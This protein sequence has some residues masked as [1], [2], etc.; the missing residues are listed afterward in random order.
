[1]L[2]EPDFPDEP[3]VPD[4][5]AP[6]NVVRLETPATPADGG[7]AAA[8]T[9]GEGAESAAKPKRGR[10]PK[11][12]ELGVA[13]YIKLVTGFALIYG[14]KTVWDEANRRILPIDALRLALGN[15]AVKGWLASPNRRTVMPEQLVFEPGQSFEDG[16]INMFGGLELEP[17][18][19]KPEDV[20]P[21]LRLLRHLCSGPGVSGDDADAAMHWVLCWM[22]LPLQRLGTKMQTAIVMHG[23]QGTGKNLFWDVWRDLYG[24][25]GVTVSQTELEDKFNEWLSC[26]LAIVGDEVV[27]R[28]EM[29]HN[30]NRLKL[31]VTQSAKFPIR[32]MHQSTRWESNHANVVFL[33]NE[34]QP[35][36]L[37]ERDRRYMVIYT[38]LE[39]DEALYDSVKAFLAADG[40]RKW[41]HYLLTYA[42]EGFTP[43][44]K[45]LMT[46]AKQA[47]ITAGYKP[48]QRF[49]AEW[50]GG[51]LPLAVQVCS[52]EQLYRVF[53]R[54]A[55]QSGERF[56][57][58]REIFSREF[59]RHLVEMAGRGKDP[60]LSIKII[61]LATAT[62][63]KSV[64]CWL[65]LNA[66]P[67]A[68]FS[69][70]GDWATDCVQA[71]ERQ[72]EAYVRATGGRPLD[73]EDGS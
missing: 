34:S 53:R 27:S 62:G 2:P 57:P 67:G 38:P 36:A 18:A 8:K 15:D 60:G 69:S 63:R 23:A 16:R 1:M 39:A 11:A 19:C 64:R 71:F 35:L 52:A 40:A 65:P 43:H 72:I 54:W 3:D 48:S 44:T 56:L 42:V 49:A 24:L 12:G 13:N 22:A 47:L 21:M 58:S 31:V 41:L 46:E 51:L 55:E 6:P 70:E 32:A 68:D 29:Y 33:S 26:K 20:A 73:S 30:K 59:G 4:A 45:P 37:E 7:G 61:N 9:G 10:K 28:Q 17:L 50:M 66:K 5:H 25:Y 14:T